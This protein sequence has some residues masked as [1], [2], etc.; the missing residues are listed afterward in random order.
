[1]IVSYPNR[2]ARWVLFH[3]WS[4][5]NFSWCLEKIIFLP[6]FKKINILLKTRI[7]GHLWWPFFSPFG[8]GKLF[9][10]VSICNSLNNSERMTI[11]GRNNKI[12]KEWQYSEGMTLIQKKWQQCWQTDK[13]RLLWYR[14]IDLHGD[15]VK[16][17]FGLK[18]KNQPFRHSLNIKVLHYRVSLGFH[19]HIL[20]LVAD[21]MKS[22]SKEVTLPN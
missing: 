11:F 9:E 10:L 3:F 13:N 18:S 1:M 4:Y 8:Y 21:Q 20:Y 2:T 17:T 16:N 15:K 5:K 14:L 22:Q 7:Y 6:I 12:R 19:G